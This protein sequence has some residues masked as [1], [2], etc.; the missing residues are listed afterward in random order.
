MAKYC[1]KCGRALPDGVEICPDC[2]ASGAEKDDAALFTRMTAETEVWKDTSIPE[3][4]EKRRKKIY[5]MRERL[6]LYLA[7][8]L[9]VIFTAF[10]I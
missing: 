2:H 7:A 10:I 5:S 8:V 1:S 6:M 3:K 9:L 4:R